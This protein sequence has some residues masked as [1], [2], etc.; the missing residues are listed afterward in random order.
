MTG[1]RRLGVAAIAAFIGVA[2]WWI[3]MAS[4]P[5]YSYGSEADTGNPAFFPMLAAAAF[6][7]GVAV[8]RIPGVIATMLVL[9][10]LIAAPW[11]TPRGDGDGL[12]VMIFPMLVAFGLVLALF[13]VAGAKAGEFARQRLSR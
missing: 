13:A 10:P 2:T 1:T 7:L 6:L 8:P 5:R 9:P 11:T 3:T 12:W 4:A